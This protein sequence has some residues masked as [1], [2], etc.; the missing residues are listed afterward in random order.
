MT[1]RLSDD[2][3]HAS[4]SRER[5]HAS[6][7]T[8]GRALI[9]LVAMQCL[10]FAGDGFEFMSRPEVKRTGYATDSNE[11]RTA[12]LQRAMGGVIALCLMGLMGAV[13]VLVVLRIGRSDKG[14]SRKTPRKQ[15][16]SESI[17]FED[18]EDE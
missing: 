11:E 2:G 18:D 12:R 16:R 14:K 4:F 1:R 8:F 9:A 7:S 3:C 15:T 10:A 5:F 6:V 17:F 13:F